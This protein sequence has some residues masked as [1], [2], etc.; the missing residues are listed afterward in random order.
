MKLSYSCTK[1]V[2]NIIQNHNKKV[3]T[4]PPNTN[5]KKCNCRVKKDCPLDNNCLQKSV[6]YKATVSDGAQYIGSTEDFKKRY[7]QHKSN[8]RNAN[9]KNATALSKYIWDRNLNPNPTI[10]WEILTTAP[11][12]KKGLRH[13]SLCL[14]EKLFIARNIKNPKCINKRTDIAMKCKHKARHRLAMMC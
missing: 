6:I 1:N 3:C 14:T 10:Q 8:F 5:E 9:T 12:Y 4:T 7:I 11:L 2:K 13:C